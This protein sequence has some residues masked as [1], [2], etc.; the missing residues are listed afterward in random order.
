MFVY[1]DTYISLYI[2]AIYMYFFV[3]LLSGVCVRVMPFWMGWIVTTPQ[4]QR[5]EPGKV[6]FLLRNSAYSDDDDVRQMD[7]TNDRNLIPTP[8][9]NWFIRP[10]LHRGPA[11]PFFDFTVFIRAADTFYVRREKRRQMQSPYEIRAFIIE[12]CSGLFFAVGAFEPYR[13][14]DL[15]GLRHLDR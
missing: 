12:G 5:P 11:I 6:V 15:A 14:A 3:W 9:A 2:N 10:K 1:I 4:P 13:L 7:A 8:V